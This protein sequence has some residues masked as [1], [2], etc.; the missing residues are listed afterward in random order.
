MT[1]PMELILDRAR[2]DKEESLEDKVRRITITPLAIQ[3]YKAIGNDGGCTPRFL[4]AIATSF[5]KHHKLYKKLG[6]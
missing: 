1:E 4:K 2:H 3:M 6:E 5:S